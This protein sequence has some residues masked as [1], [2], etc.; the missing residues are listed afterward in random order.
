M[1][2]AIT[3]D[4]GNPGQ[5]RVAAKLF[6]GNRVLQAA[7]LCPHSTAAVFAAFR[8]GRLAGGSDVFGALPAGCDLIAVVARAQL[9]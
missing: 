6:A 8:A 4:R 1:S 5:A 9:H 2:D 3:R 7:R